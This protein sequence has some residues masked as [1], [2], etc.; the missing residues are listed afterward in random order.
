MS[1]YWKFSTEDS[2][3]SYLVGTMHLAVPVPRIQLLNSIL[4]NADRVCL[5]LDLDLMSSPQVQSSFMMR[6]ASS[7]LDRFSVHQVRR[8]QRSIFKSFGIN[9]EHYRR[10]HPMVLLNQLSSSSMEQTERYSIDQYI[11][12]SAKELKKITAGIEKVEEQMAVLKAMGV[13]DMARGIRAISKNTVAFRKTHDRMAKAYE[14]EDIHLLQ[15]LA[16]KS[17]SVRKGL[18]LKERNFRMADR[19][20][21]ELKS[22]KRITVNAIGAGH[23]AGKNGVINLLRNREGVKIKALS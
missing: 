9:I 12:N 22:S 11:W 7:W 20:F 10:L 21:K 16:K 15:R 2:P 5:E 4:D 14:K 3:C 19:I 8:M 13:V 23:L 1:I 17:I 6:G 18:L